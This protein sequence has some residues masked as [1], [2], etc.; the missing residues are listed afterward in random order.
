[1]STPTSMHEASPS[2]ALNGLHATPHSMQ[3]SRTAI[4][5]GSAFVNG[6]PGGGTTTTA[7]GRVDHW[8]RN[9]KGVLVHMPG[10][11]HNPADVISQPIPPD[12][13]KP[14][15]PAQRA[16]RPPVEPLGPNQHF[17][18]SFRAQPIGS[19]ST[20]M[21]GDDHAFAGGR[22]RDGSRQHV[23]QP[24]P[25]KPRM[26]SQP[27]AAASVMEGHQAPGSG[28]DNLSALAEVAHAQSHLVRSA[29]N[30]D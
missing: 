24:P 28:L 6:L 27:G 5:D 2:P 23:Y 18:G 8:T 14:R 7:S 22:G 9:A 16:P 13:P 12:P 4:L 10:A 19:S 20:G 25:T 15:K 21:L 17:A 30:S 1:M 29:S 26:A 3:A 11:Y